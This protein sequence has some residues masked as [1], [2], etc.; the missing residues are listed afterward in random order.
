MPCGKAYLFVLD[1][2]IDID[3]DMCIISRGVAASSHRHLCYQH[4]TLA[5]VDQCKAR[6]EFKP[7]LMGQAVL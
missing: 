1:I 2:D 3:I 6:S 4:F 5:I 7:P